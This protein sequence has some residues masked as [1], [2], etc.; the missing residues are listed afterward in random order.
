[1]E[2]QATQFTRIFLKQILSNE[3]SWKRRLIMRGNLL[4]VGKLQVFD[5]PMLRILDVVHAY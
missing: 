1:M 2:A 5:F 4:H 3:S